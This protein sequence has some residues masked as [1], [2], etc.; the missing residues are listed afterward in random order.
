METGSTVEVEVKVNRRTE[1][2]K[3]RC[4]RESPRGFMVREGSRSRKRV[5]Q[6]KDSFEGR[7]GEKDRL[8][9]EKD[10]REFT[11][12]EGVPPE[13]PGESTLV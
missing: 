2:D 7:K 8:R 10:R 5:P 6:E 3:D 13:G 12:K 11:G 1:G 9:T 4:D